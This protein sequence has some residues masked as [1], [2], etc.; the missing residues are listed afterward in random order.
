MIV[1]LASRTS[2]GRLA[3]GKGTALADM[4]AGSTGAVFSE[5]G[6]RMARG[7]ER[8]IVQEELSG[9]PC[10]KIRVIG[11]G[12]PEEVLWDKLVREHHY[13][14]YQ[15]LLGRRLKYLAYIGE[16]PVSALSW[17]A[18]ALKLR[19]RDHWIGWTPEQRKDHLHR[20]SNNSRFI[21]F[22]W[23]RVPNLA[24]Y[25]LGRVLKR[26]QGDWEELYGERLW[27]VETFVDPRYFKGTSYRAA[28]WIYVGQSSGSGKYRQGYAYH[29]HVKEVYVYELDRRFRQRIGCHA[30]P[31][32]PRYR[33]PSWKSEIKMGELKMIIREATWKPDVV[34]GVEL[35]S[36]DVEQVAEELIRFHEDFRSCFK[37]QKNERLGLAYLTGLL[38]NLESKSIEPIALEFLGQGGVRNSQRFMKSYRWKE[39]EMLELYQQKL[40]EDIGASGGMLTV[41]SSEFPKKG[42]ESVG[43]AR[44]Y[45]GSMGKVDNCQSGVFVG[46][47][48][49]K[50][51][52]LLNAQLYMPK[53]WFS[54]EQKERREFNKVPE[55]LGFRTKPQIALEMIKQTCAEGLFPVQWVGCDTTFGGDPDFLDGLPEN[56][57]YFAQVRASTQ[58]FLKKPKV[59]LPPYK[60]R[61][62]LPKKKKILSENVSIKTVKEVAQ[63]CRKWRPVILAEGAK[64]PIVAHVAV[65]RVW[66]ARQG[67]PKDE[68]EWLFLRR[69]EDGQIKYAFS[70]APEDTPIEEL[71]RIS[72]LRWS[73]EQCFKE[74][75]DQLGMDH[76]EHR[77]WPAWHRHMIYVFLAMLFLLR[78]RIRFKK[79]SGTHFAPGTKIDCSSIATKISEH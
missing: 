46:Y 4:C 33:P 26:L 63:G 75:K 74:G 31:Y 56:V 22:P 21:V 28:N 58:V 23:V 18:A 44:Q 50:G 12:D 68:A 15:K 78:L 1:P 73:I 53:G 47:C 19:V 32:N 55:S 14:G 25:V 76:Y 61:G 17:S 77:S 6:T 45:C 39:Q 8:G 64:G 79:N 71:V 36:K 69:N 37:G 51:Y 67:L 27:L 59:G 42:K 20:V 70:N 65:Y 16:S 40:S 52:G 24:S 60:G 29:G 43:V 7:F 72:M 57:Y 34:P 30:K 41:D 13:L 3:K 48:S 2:T 9:L 5:A 35:D 62:A 54:E 10:V 49:Q 11:A 38:S 66:Q